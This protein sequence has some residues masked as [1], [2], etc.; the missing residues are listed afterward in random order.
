MGE[1]AAQGFVR[2][3]LAPEADS[4]AQFLAVPGACR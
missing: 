3:G 4:V 2:A 1:A